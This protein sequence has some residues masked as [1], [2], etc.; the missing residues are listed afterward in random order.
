[1]VEPFVSCVTIGKPDDVVI[2][3]MIV[4]MAHSLNMTVIAEGVEN[5]ENLEFLRSI[6]CDELQGYILSHPLP[7]DEVVSLLQEEKNYLPHHI[8]D[9][10]A[11]DA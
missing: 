1:M 3:K 4:G 2:A 8:L 6:Q 7:A 9:V 10:H 5:N 11:H